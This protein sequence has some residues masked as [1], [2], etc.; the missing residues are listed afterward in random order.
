MFVRRSPAI[1]L[2]LVLSAAAL[3]PASAW[4]SDGG[5]AEDERVGQVEPAPKKVADPVMDF[6]PCGGSSKAKVRATLMSNGEIEA[7]GVVFSGDDDVW[8]WKFKH[9]GDFSAM[10]EVKAR[11]ADR[12]FR[13]VRYMV[14]F[15]GPDAV[16]FRAQNTATGE[17]C[18]VD[19][20]V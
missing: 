1:V 10:G 3:V 5:T 4:A 16:F 13:V 14:D 7:V 9:N 12:S 6:E 20:T 15:S 19:V 11:D 8:D 17:V 2:G 18:K